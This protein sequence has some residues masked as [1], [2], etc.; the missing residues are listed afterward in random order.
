MYYIVY[1]T[2][3]TVTNSIYIGVHVTSN[4]DDGYLGSGKVL[5]RAIAKY[6]ADKF[7]KTILHIFDNIDEMFAME[8]QLVNEEFIQRPD[9]YNIKLGGSGGWDY[10]NKNGLNFT[11]EKNRAIS[12]FKKVDPQLRKQW[13][14]KGAQALKD[15]Y[16]KFHQG[17]IDDPHPNREAFTFKGKS[18]TVQTKEKMSRSQK[19]RGNSQGVRN[20][21]FGTC[22]IT[23]GEQNKKIKKTEPIPIGWKLGRKIK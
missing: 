12:G 5:L 16:T 23:N 3:N 17:L 20:S 1:Q 18:H 2:T 10:I 21:Q 7:E 14:Q 9:T 15:L 6:G 11:Y 4:I 13:G 19:E 8:A 22:W